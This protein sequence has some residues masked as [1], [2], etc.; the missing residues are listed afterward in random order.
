MGCHFLL[1]GSS[2][3]RDGTCVSYVSC[4]GRQILYHWRH[5]GS[6]K[7]PMT[8]INSGQ[9]SSKANKLQTS[10]RTI[11]GDITT[12]PIHIQSIIRGIVYNITDWN[13]VI[14]P[15]WWLSSFLFFSFVLTFFTIKIVIQT[16]LQITG[17]TF[18]N[19]KSSYGHLWKMLCY[20][21]FY[22]VNLLFWQQRMRWLDSITDSTDMNLNKLWEIVENRG[23]WHVRVHWVAKSQTRL[24]RWATTTN[25]I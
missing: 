23:A 5:P 21:M 17:S 19:F 2:W 11:E 13:F 12:Y 20:W 10:N 9:N 4:F 22:T 7:R 25:L 15:L 8:V 6:P 1:Q 18:F 24:G 16:F 3:P 14:S